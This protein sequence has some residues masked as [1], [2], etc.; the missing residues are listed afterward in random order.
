MARVRESRQER[1]REKIKA[2][3]RAKVRETD[4]QTE[5]Q[6]E[7]Q[8]HRES[9]R[10][11]VKERER[12]ERDRERKG[13]KSQGE[14]ESQGERERESWHERDGERVKARESQDERESRKMQSGNGP[15]NMKKPGTFKGKHEC[16]SITGTHP[17]YVAPLTTYPDGLS[18]ESKV[19]E[20]VECIG[21]PIEYMEPPCSP[22]KDAPE[23][24]PCQPDG[25]WFTDGSVRKI[26]EIADLLDD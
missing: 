9:V 17:Y 18:K 7:S 4:R 13:E 15:H 3:E 23:F 1:Q 16:I 8:G 2:R 5:R 21:M 25:I 11:R 20:A 26:Q 12:E 24:D 6:K 22:I 14:K 19:T 10:G